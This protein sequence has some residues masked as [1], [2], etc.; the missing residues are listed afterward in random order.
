MEGDPRRCGKR[1][2][3]HVRLHCCCRQNYLS[4]KM[5]SD[6]SRFNILLIVRYKVTKQ[7]PLTSTVE[8]RGEPKF[9]SSSSSI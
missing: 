4:I 3:I 6:Q 9:S 1:E 7:C 5:G 2:S 8:E